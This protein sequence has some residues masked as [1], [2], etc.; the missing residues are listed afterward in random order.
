MIKHILLD[1][2]GTTCPVSFVSDIL[3]PYASKHLNTFIQDNSNQ[4]HCA[5][6][7]N[8]AWEEWENDSTETSRQL[9]NKLGDKQTY[10]NDSICIYLQHLINVDRKSTALKEIQGLIWKEGYKEGLL[11]SELFPETTDCLKQWAKKGF[12]LST[13]SSG[14]I[15]AQKQLYKNTKAGDLCPLFSGWFD[16]HT[17]PKRERSSYA[18]IA[19]Q[20]N[21]LPE[22]IVFISD[23]HL[24][25][26]AALQAGLR[27]LFSK[28]QGNPD[29]DPAG[30]TTIQS[31]REVMAFLKPHLNVNACS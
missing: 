27:T 13:Y 1:I 28:R 26:N 30:H 22:E 6:L 18:L 29:Q 2:E 12:Q 31:L 25:C 19:E 17:G 7:I 11:V 21:A 14:S 16:T 24:E 4:D 10:K 8:E 3:F 20:L 15:E 9:L 5:K 23:S